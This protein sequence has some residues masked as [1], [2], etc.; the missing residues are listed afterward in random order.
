MYLRFNPH[1]V[2]IQGVGYL[3]FAPTIL[4]FSSQ[5]DVSVGVLSAMFVCRAVGSAMGS[6]GAG[7]LLDRVHHFAYSFMSLVFI[8]SIVS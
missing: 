6:V 8:A 2:F 7:L 1:H 5:L 3:V 4:D